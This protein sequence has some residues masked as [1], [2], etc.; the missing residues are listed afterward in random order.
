MKSFSTFLLASLLSLSLFAQDEQTITVNTL[1]PDTATLYK[2][3]YLYPSFLTGYVVFR[4]QAPIEA[5]LNY[6]RLF[7]Q[8]LFLTPKG[9]TLAMARAE[10]TTLVTVG[11]DTFYFYD[12]TFVQK[13]S[14]N[15]NAPNLFVRQSLKYIGAEK[16][17]AYGTYSPVTA[18][19]SNSTFSADNQITQY[20]AIDENRLYKTNTE[21]FLSDAFNNLFP[22]SKSRFYSI[23]SRQEKALKAYADANNIDFRK[24]EDMLK[25]LQYAVSL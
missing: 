1:H 4:D 3:V 2:S 9:D 13:L 7:G 10:E 11:I 12:K 6:N 19:N 14:H 15:T 18:V 24:K 8:M 21:Y 17:G 20:L 5:K 22:C 23:F 16:K 25:I